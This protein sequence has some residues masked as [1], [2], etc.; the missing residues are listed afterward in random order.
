MKKIIRESAHFKF[1][2]SKHSPPGN[3]NARPIYIIDARKGWSAADLDMEAVRDIVDPQRSI[4]GKN[5]TRWKFRN[6]EDAN[7]LW[8]YLMLRWS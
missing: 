5:G 3:A 2:H 4:S 1:I 8:V 6:Y 7:K